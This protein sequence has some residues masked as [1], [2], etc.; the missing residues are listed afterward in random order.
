MTSDY[1]PKEQI[2]VGDLKLDTKAKKYLNEVIESNR[3]SYGPFSQKLEVN[4]AREHQCKYGVFCNSGTSALHIALA[5][6]K[7]KYGWHD[8]A[9]VIVPAVTF[10]ATSNIVLHNNMKPVFVDVSSDSYTIDPELIEKSIT[11]RT[12]AIIPVHL[13]GLPCDMDPILEIAKKHN[14]RII[15]DSCE[16][17]FARYKGKTVG[18]FGDIGCF[19]TYVAHLLVTGVGGFA[20]T[21]NDE[22]AVML[23]GLMNHGRDSIYLHIDD[24]KGTSV[25]SLFEIVSRRFNFVSLGYS[26]RATE[27]EAAIGLA[28]LEQKSEIVSKRQRNAKYLIRALSDLDEYLQLPCISDEREHVFMMFPI[29]LKKEPKTDLVKYLEKNNVETR[30]MMPLLTQP[31]YKRLFGEIIDNYP[32]A[33]WI[34]THGFYIGCHQSLTDEQLDYVIKKIRR[35]F[36]K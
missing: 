16:T 13:F 18:S 23:K 12:R 10:I 7:E 27:L 8:G 21:N 11:G 32:V 20:I 6:L 25:E 9:E 2:G 33:K 29:V 28:Q 17:M 36:K 30:D 19:S 3:L 31:V 22:L 15:E 24:D 4:F 14:L 1:K 34:G 35:H 5:A 26:F